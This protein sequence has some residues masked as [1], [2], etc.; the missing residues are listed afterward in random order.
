[1][2][3]FNMLFVCLVISASTFAQDDMWEVYIAQYDEGAG[4]TTVNMSLVENAHKSTLP[5][6]SLPV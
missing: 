6:S 5:L 3:K 1:M 2:M 4:S